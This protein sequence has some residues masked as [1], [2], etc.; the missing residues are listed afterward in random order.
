VNT[1][2]WRDDHGARLFVDLERSGNAFGFASSE[3]RNFVEKNRLPYYDGS[4]EYCLW[5]GC[6]GAYDPQGREIVLALA[7][8]LRHLGVKFGVPRKERCTGDPARRLGNDLAASQ[9]AEAN[10]ETLRAAGVGKMVSICPHCVR[11][12]GMGEGHAF[13]GEELLGVDGV[14]DGDE[15]VAEVGDFLEAFE[16]DDGEGGAGEEVFAGM[17]GRTGFALRGGEPGGLGGERFGG[18]GLMG[19]RHCETT[20]RFER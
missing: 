5:L 9:A 17:L 3:R 8:V 11:R 15:V 12:I 14:V 18:D 7:R 19:T 10:I 1:G 6:M 2:R 20:L 16:A 13:E 4:Q